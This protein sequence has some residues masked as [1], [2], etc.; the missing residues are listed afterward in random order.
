MNTGGNIGQLCVIVLSGDVGPSCA[1]ASVALQ[2]RDKE[3]WDLTLEG[4]SNVPLILML[5][6]TSLGP[7][8]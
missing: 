6:C 3:C 4:L 8:C 5:L 1:K 7:H 2:Q